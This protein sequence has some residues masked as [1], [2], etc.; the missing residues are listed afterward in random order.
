VKDKPTI[1][2]TKLESFTSCLCTPPGNLACLRCEPV[3]HGYIDLGGL[4]GDY[5]HCETCRVHW[6]CPT[7]KA[8]SDA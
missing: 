7:A 8:A 2:N 5:P 3:G 6:P 4:D 1:Q